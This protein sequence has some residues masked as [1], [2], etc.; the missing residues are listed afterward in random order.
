[1]VFGRVASNL[2]GAQA[3]KEFSEAFGF[4]HPIQFDFPVEMSRASI[5]EQSY[6][7]AGAGG[8]WGGYLEP[9]H[10]ALIA[11]TIANQGG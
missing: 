1:V 11:A 5:P 7:L 10:A 9:L 3:L 6:E 2:L 8:V 4:N